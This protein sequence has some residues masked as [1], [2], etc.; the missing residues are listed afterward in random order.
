MNLIFLNCT[1]KIVKMTSFMLC[2]FYHNEKIFLNN[3]GFHDPSCQAFK[4]DIGNIQSDASCP[5][6]NGKICSLLSGFLVTMPSLSSP[7]SSISS[8]GLSY[9]KLLQVPLLTLLST[10]PTLQGQICCDFHLGWFGGSSL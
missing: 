9:L 4:I 6:K 3:Y 7:S 2:I 1:L 5:E 10:V 8:L